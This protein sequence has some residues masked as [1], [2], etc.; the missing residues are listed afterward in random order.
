MQI[1]QVALIL[2]L[3]ALSQIAMSF[4]MRKKAASNP[5]SRSYSRWKSLFVMSLIL[6]A[7]SLLLFILI[8]EK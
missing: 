7:S 4:Y 2:G 6:L 1:W 5:A 8:Q 3:V